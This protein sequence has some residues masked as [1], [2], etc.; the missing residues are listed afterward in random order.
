MNRKLLS[1]ALVCTMCLS[2]IP[3]P[4]AHAAD[5]TLYVSPLGEEGAYASL[6]EAYA[7]ASDGDTICIRG[8]MEL[9]A[10]VELD[11]GKSVTLT[12]EGGVLTYT[13]TTN[14]S[15]TSA[16]VLTV[17]SG[18]VTIR[19][20]TVQMRSEKTTNGRPLYVGPGADVTLGSGSVIANG[21]LAYS[22]GNVYVDGG[23]LT[24]ENGATVRDAHIANN[25]DCFGGGVW[26]A[27]GGSFEMNGGK[28]INNTVHTTQSYD[29]YGGGV[30]VDSTSAF[31][32]SGG[33]IKDNSVD[34]AGGG[35]YPFVG[36]TLN[37]GGNLTVW[38]NQANGEAGNLYLPAGASFS[39]TD[40]LSGQVGLSCE[41]SDYG[42][43]VGTASG[44]AIQPADEDAFAY[45]SGAYD[46]RLKN[47][48]LVLYYFTVGVNLALD[49]VDSEN[50]EQENPVGQ[51][52]DTVLVPQEGYLLPDSITVTVGG[53]TLNEDL[54][55][56][57]QD[58]GVL[59]IPS[60]QVVGNIGIT[61]NGDAIRDITVST[62]N[63]LSD[64]ESTTA[65]YQD[66]V[67]IQ[68][69]A[70][71]RYA[72]PTEEDISISGNC[73]QNYDR[74]T[75]TLILTNI[76]S[77]L[78]IS[79]QGAEIYHTLTFD[80][81]EGECDPTSVE[82]TESQPTLGTLPEPFL[83]GY[84][85]SGWFAGEERVTAETENHLTDDLHLVA[86]WTQKTNITYTVEQW[87]EYVASGIN[88]GYTG[89]DLQSMTY[90][91]VTHKY[92]RYAAI[93]SEDGIAN[94][95]LEMAPWTLDSLSD[96]LSMDGFVPSG[97]NEYSVIIS[98]DGSSVFPLFYDR[99]RYT[100]SYDANGGDLGSGA[101][102]TTVTYGGQ[103]SVLPTAGREGY[104]LLGW[105]TEAHG[106]NQ[107]QAGDECKATADHTLYAHWTPEGN[108]AYTVYHMTQ[109]LH[110]N[111]VSADKT[112]D[113]YTATH[114][115]HLK[116]TSDTVVDLYAMA[117]EGFTPCEDNNYA[118]T[119]LADGSA[120][121]YLYYDRLVTDVSFEPCGGTAVDYD[122]RL[123]YG[124][125]FAFLP[126]APQRMGY[127]FVGW[128]TG[129][130]PTAQ[131][132]EA[133]LSINEINPEGLNHIAL[134]ARWSPK[135]Y[136]LT[137][138]AHGGTLSSGKTVTFDQPIG[139]LPTADLTGYNFMGWYD[140]DGK[141]GEPEGDLITEDTSA[142]ALIRL[143]NGVES[144]KTLYAWYEAMEITL[145]FDPGDGL[146]LS[147][148]NVTLTYDRQ[149]GELPAPIREGYTFRGWR[150]NS[151]EG[152]LI[153]ED[154]ISKVT[155]DSTAY[156]EYAPNLYVV[157]L[158][159]AGG[160][161]LD[162][163]TL[164]GTFDAP[165]G[166]PTP[167]RMGH[168]FQG[169]F[170]EQG[171]EVTAETILTIAAS[172][173]LTAR[174]EANRY[175]VALEVN[176]GEALEEDTSISLTYGQPYGELPTPKRSGYTFVGWFTD[177]EKG[178]LVGKN[179]VLSTASDH[180]LYA[181]WRANSSSGGGF[182][183]G[184]VVV[185]PTIYTLTFASF[186]GSEIPNLQGVADTVVD[187]AQYKP[188]RS[189]YTFLG[190]SVDGVEMVSTV[191]LKGDLTLR[192]MWEQTNRLGAI[193]E[194]EI[195]QAYLTGFPD[196][197]V[198]PN[199]EIT[200]AE[201]VQ[202][203]YRLMTT[204]AHM[205]YDTTENSFGDVVD[206][207][208]FNLSVSTLAN[209]GIIVGRDDGLFCPNATITRAELTTILARLE[210]GSY[211]EDNDRF[212]DIAEHWANREIN[213]LADLGWVKG[214]DM[215]LFR[216]DASM[217][218]AEAVAVLNRA[219]GRYPETAQDLLPDVVIYPDNADPD[220]WY[221][222][223]ILE[224]ANGHNYTRKAD[225]VHERWVQGK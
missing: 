216:P 23:T 166:L 35:I 53:K 10:P 52:Y 159:V 127:N 132:V 12:G 214:D 50:E 182:V 206:D 74:G 163:S 58:S 141:L 158:D 129:T 197:T 167:T 24:M 139:E 116:G 20:L 67:V 190:W 193:L 88:P 110:D 33:T 90:N 57:D 51:D 205:R 119:I 174:W 209:M 178:L 118:L 54:Y 130:N 183:G 31:T 128:Y 61:V 87:L 11:E 184:T 27:N 204:D 15:S 112:A 100:V 99:N 79:I 91:G 75:G 161:A 73:D 56:Y 189:G 199:A 28:I 98:P 198:Q 212:P 192:A 196:G 42:L 4:A 30:A 65:I 164:M 86:R 3:A 26:V 220:A 195:H 37:L 155:E 126:A 208:W 172:H 169:W 47:D 63:V 131:K 32:M 173:T 62:Q 102:S 13:D 165:Y 5:N 46:V 200:R 6:Q 39:L 177:V 154:T 70:V 148:G 97:A 152:E 187:L 29:S 142:T 111:T 160:D 109:V 144:P 221:Y 223:D 22:G 186:G 72:L 92:Y 25:T 14:I 207:D 17:R 84:A 18:H 188:V 2:M 170:D 217:T 96:G 176:G 93:T 19:D 7:A 49:G 85:F 44:Y 121:A 36:A 136:D 115:D 113:N 82:I 122:I 201:V 43:T 191:T 83:E 225:G 48:D 215:G 117:L 89:G 16:G 218:R 222:L 55:D 143:D 146:L 124:G 181:H 175:T 135:T 180:I 64:V 59:H 104:T 140:E 219:L 21:Y 34:T 94:G 213:H 78:A 202:L 107:V 171:N 138:E 60:D 108:T 66:T 224:A 210:G 156:A 81:G 103:Y 9:D 133:G 76:A 41:A 137:F 211:A 120:V 179:T 38:G 150:L 149:V 162:K 147:N 134:Y 80:P 106:G 151:L 95:R 153:T 69:T 114:I 145:T 105:F 203:L 185:A 125:T 45:D 101:V 8:E 77:D 123:Y 1:M 157:R 71:N 68:L 40:A 194:C 168:T